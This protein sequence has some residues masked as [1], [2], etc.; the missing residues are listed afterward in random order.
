[1]ILLHAVRQ[2][3]GAD[4][5]RTGLAVGWWTEICCRTGAQAGSACLATPR[6]HC[7]VRFQR[8]HP[9][10]DFMTND[11][12]DSIA[13]QYQKTAGFD[14]ETLNAQPSWDVARRA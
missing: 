13:L 1:M 4:A 11:E 2:R 5:V 10:D 14:V 7:P 3:L 6:I 12:L 8:G 9:G